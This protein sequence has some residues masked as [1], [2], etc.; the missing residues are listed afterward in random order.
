MG[1][2]QQYRK[3]FPYPME[4][5]VASYSISTTTRESESFSIKKQ[6]YYYIS[7]KSLYTH[8]VRNNNHP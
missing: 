7:F 5:E 1:G 6:D 2:I 4:S 8:R 3:D